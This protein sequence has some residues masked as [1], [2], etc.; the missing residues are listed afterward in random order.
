MPLRPR[1]AV[2]RMAAVPHGG[3]N[4]G[5]LDRLGIAPDEV[6][7]FSANL[8]PFGPPAGVTKA[9]GEVDVTRYP[10]SDSAEFRSV[11]AK[12]LG[13][14]P[15]NILAGNGSTEIIR[16][17]ALGYL[18]NGDKVFLIE[19]T[20]GEYEAACQLA[21]ATAV[22]HRLS[23]ED[24][25]L[26][27]MD[28]TLALIRQ[29]RPEGIFIGNPNNP[30]GRC[31]PRA[32]LEQVLD[33]CPESL[34]VLD[35]AYISFVDKGKSCADMLVRDNLLVVRSMTKDYAMPGLRLGYGL[36]DAGII[37]VLRRLC[38][39]WNVNALAQKAGVIALQEETYLER[40]QAQLRQAKSY[41]VHELSRLGL[42][43]LPSETNFFLVEVGDA[44]DFRRRLLKRRMLVRDCR[45]FGLPRF[46]RI[47]PR[48]LADC[49]RLVEAIAESRSETSS[50]L[51]RGGEGEDRTR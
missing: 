44:A 51:K 6:L 12:K 11:L 31:I 25:F 4:Y 26:L 29:H 16:L 2:G 40:C 10:D 48:S 28:E 27:R 42:P 9:L 47:A 3:I 37:S 36:A 14:Q 49:R 43:P 34:V 38:P 18:G 5:E 21:G 22:K 32:G 30:T 15:E 19:P 17:A 1:P 7:D 45:S 39:P 35:E 24:A 23:P 50:P 13:V 20:F 8:N 46:V 41:L 33:S